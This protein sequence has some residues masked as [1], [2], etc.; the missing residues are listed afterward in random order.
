MGSVMATLT[1]HLYDTSPL[2]DN[3]GIKLVYLIP[4]VIGGS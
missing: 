2:G 4:V 3:Q 1:L